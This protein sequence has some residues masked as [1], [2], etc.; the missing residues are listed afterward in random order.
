MPKYERWINV[1]PVNSKPELLIDLVIPHTPR[2]QARPRATV[3]KC[4]GYARA[5]MYKPRENILAEEEVR[6]YWLDLV[7]RMPPDVAAQFPWPG[8]VKMA[9]VYV[10]AP[11]KSN[12]WEGKE[13]ISKPDMDNLQKMFQDALNKYA[14]VDDSQ[15]IGKHTEKCYGE[16][17]GTYATLEFYLPVEKPVKE[18]RTAPK[19]KTKAQV[20]AELRKQEREEKLINII[21]GKE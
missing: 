4:G 21:E 6:R 1:S 9:V 12:Y 11:P 3:I 16:K 7:E 17:E 18:K 5:T 14:W 10:F 15:I 8:P 19:K 2:A 13:K 20:A